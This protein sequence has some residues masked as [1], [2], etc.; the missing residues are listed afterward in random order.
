MPKFNLYQSLHTTVIGPGGK[1]LEIQI[2]TFDMHQTAEF[3]VAAHW[4]YKEKGDATTRRQARLAAPDDGVAVRDAGD[5]REFMDTL[6]I[7]LFE[8]E[9]FVF[10][11]KGDVK[12]LGGRLAR[13]S[14][15]PTRCTPTSAAT[16]WAPR[17]TAASCR[18]TPSCKSGDIV[19]I[20]T[21]QVEPRALARLARHR[22]H[23]ARAPEDP[24]ALPPRAA[25][26]HRALGPRPAAGGAAPRGAAGPE[27]AV[28]RGLRADRQGRRLPEGRRPLRRPRLGPHAGA[29]PWSTRCM[30]RSGGDEGG[31]ARRRRCCPP[32]PVPERRRAAGALER[33]R[34]RRRGHERHRGAHG[35]VLQAHP[36]RRDRRLHLARQGRHHPPRR[37]QE[38]ARPHARTRERFTN[39]DWEG[40]GGRPSASRSG[41]GARPQPPARGHR[42]HA[43]RLGREHRRRRQCRRCPTAS[44]ATASCSRSA[45]S[46][47]WPTSSPTSR[48]PSAPSTTPTG[49]SAAERA[50]LAGGAR[51]GRRLDARSRGRA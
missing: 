3:G 2:R 27:A 46:A 23:A 5:P 39:V 11:P 40:L 18:C 35:Q 34:H 4:L 29:R 10:T 32:S 43:V 26:G 6:R 16:A 51:R 48:R 31:D 24:P 28:V 12:S 38:R 49:W 44:S 36:R 37:L 15:S 42:P 17:S 19:E 8:D 33:V 47:S 14:T 22:Q 50:A 13:R 20:I 41:R 45:T 7:D 30:Q 21:T 9:V 1:P 25:R